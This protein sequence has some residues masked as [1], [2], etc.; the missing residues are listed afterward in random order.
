MLKDFLSSIFIYLFMLIFFYFTGRISHHSLS[1]ILNKNLL[2]FIWQ[3]PDWEILYEIAALNQCTV[4]CLSKCPIIVKVTGHRS[5]T[6]L[7][8]NFFTDIF[9]RLYHTISLILCRTAIMK[10]IYFCIKVFSMTAFVHSINS[11]D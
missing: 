9:Q 10:S 1:I 5:A 7:T 3:K 8:L 6:L 4:L 2:L 11:N